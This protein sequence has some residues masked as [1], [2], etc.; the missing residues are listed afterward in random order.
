SSGPR[1]MA[2]VPEEKSFEL[3]GDMLFKES[4]E[5]DFHYA[6]DRELEKHNRE[7]AGEIY[8]EMEKAFPEHRLTWSANWAIARYD[9]NTLQLLEAVEG[10]RKQFPEDIN[11]KL[12]YLSVSSEQTARTERLKT[13]EEF[14]KQEKTD[15][16]LW[17]M[18]GC[19]LGLDARHHAR[20]LH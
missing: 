18:F 9:A 15:P 17:Q 11:L 13:L 4:R 20:A 5:Y 12:S 8:A 16:L 6:V 10:L 3:L 1:G 14:C 2:L 7:K 19:E